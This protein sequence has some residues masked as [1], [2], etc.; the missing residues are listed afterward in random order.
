MLNNE[1]LAKGR[2][3]RMSQ[4]LS[5]DPAMESRYHEVIRDMEF[6]GVIEE[7][8][9]DQ[10]NVSRPIFFMPHRPVVKESSMK[11]NVRPVFDASAKGRNHVSLNDCLETG[12][13]LLPDLVGILL[14]FQRWKVAL[15]ADIT[16]AFL[17][18]EVHRDERDVHRFLWDDHGIIK[19]MRFTRVPF[20][21]KSSPFLLNATVQHHLSKFT[22]SRVVEKLSENMYVDNWISGC[23]DHEEAC[24]MTRE[25]HE[26]MNQSSMNL[27]HWVSSSLQISD[28]VINELQDKCLEKGLKVLGMEWLSSEDCFSFSGL[29]IPDDLCI[30]ERVILSCIGRFFDPLGFVALSV[31]TAKI[32]FHDL[33]RLGLG[34][35]EQVPGDC[36]QLFIKWL[37]D[38][39]CIC[40]WRIPWCYTGYAWR[41]LVSLEL[42]GF[43]NASERA[44]RA[45]STSERN[46][47]MATGH[48]H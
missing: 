16:K 8:P 25:A 37:K 48:P 9:V 19:V 4:C 18:I 30:T 47:Q 7:V 29:Q 26:V 36:C 22:P 21:N 20:G 12:P 35:D 45:M 23:D 28:L 31:M 5:K 46:Q 43:D 1:N 41:D 15:C 40:Q 44:Y 27:T 11:T 24:N 13:T 3:K 39:E 10:L 42:H 38:L 32:M 14:R 34:W 6:N 33:W 2:L 17:Q